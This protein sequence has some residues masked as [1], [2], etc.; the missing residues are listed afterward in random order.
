MRKKN[1]RNSENFKS[2][3]VE[4]GLNKDIH[5]LFLGFDSNVLTFAANKEIF[6]F[7]KTSIEPMRRDVE[8]DQNVITEV[9]NILNQHQ[10]TIYEQMRKA[11]VE[12]EFMF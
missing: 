3:L 8:A 10:Q 1:K 9:L 5:I 4:H 12:L 7:K 11:E 6:R 2:I